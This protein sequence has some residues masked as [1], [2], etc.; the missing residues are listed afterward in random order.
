VRAIT[1]RGAHCVIITYWNGQRT[2]QA[3]SL[4]ICARMGVSSE[5]DRISLGAMVRLP[6][7]SVP[8]P[9]STKW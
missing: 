9:P 8:D 5:R 6:W 4:S 3:F 2:A 7:R 1:M